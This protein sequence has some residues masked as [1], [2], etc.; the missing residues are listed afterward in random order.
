MGKTTGKMMEKT[1]RKLWKCRKRRKDKKSLS[2]VYSFLFLVLYIRV[3]FS[4]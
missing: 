1:E 2:T 4:W 3:L